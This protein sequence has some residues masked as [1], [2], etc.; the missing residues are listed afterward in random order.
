MF[1]GRYDIQVQITYR[2]KFKYN[3][4]KIGNLKYADILLLRDISLYF[5]I[6]NIFFKSEVHM[7]MKSW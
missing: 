4:Q 5:E 7:K 6:K 1:F 2:Y 3:I